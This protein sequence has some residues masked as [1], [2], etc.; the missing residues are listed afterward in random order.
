MD[1]KVYQSL[2]INIY[3]NNTNIENNYPH[4]TVTII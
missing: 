1:I 2:F 4:R 3:I